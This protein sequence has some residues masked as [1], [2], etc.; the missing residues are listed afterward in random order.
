MQFWL[1]LANPDKFQLKF[2]ATKSEIAF[3][4]D[5]FSGWKLALVHIPDFGLETYK[6]ER[7]MQFWLILANPDKF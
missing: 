4:I 5:F 1:I 2:G 7:D 6:S 3:T